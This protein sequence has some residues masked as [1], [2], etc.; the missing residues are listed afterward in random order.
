VSSFLILP[1]IGDSGPGHWQTTWEKTLPD[2]VR[3]SARDW[4]RPVCSEWI[5]ALEWAVAKVGSDA[6]LVAHSLGCL[7]VVHWANQTAL[8]VRGALLV[9]PPDPDAAT[10][11]GDALGFRLLPK[12]RLPFASTLIAS[13]NDPFASLDFSRRCAEAWGSELVAL[14]PRGHINAESALGDWPEGRLH[15]E[16]LCGG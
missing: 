6:I 11:P 8:T 4:D 2:A 3:V 16:R 9:A 7:Q 10:F 1:G 15:L 12:V 14:G 13:A 5:A